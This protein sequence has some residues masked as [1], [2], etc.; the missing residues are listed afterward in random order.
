MEDAKEETKVERVKLQHPL[1]DEIRNMAK[2]E[3]VCKF[4]G[5]SYLIHNEIKALEDKLQ[6][7]VGQASK[8][9]FFSALSSSVSETYRHTEQAGYACY[10]RGVALD[11]C[12]VNHST[13]QDTDHVIRS[14]G[15]PAWRGGG[16]Q[17]TTMT[18]T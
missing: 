14:R 18:R 10:R 2:D 9:L 5:V 4:C 17:M 12:H 8:L 11:E 1:P 13:S 7:L 3:T 16:Q 6:V 15:G